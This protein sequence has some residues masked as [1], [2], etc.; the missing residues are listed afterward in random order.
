MAHRQVMDKHGARKENRRAGAFQ[1]DGHAVCLTAEAQ[2]E[3]KACK[4][5]L[6]L[7]GKRR[8]WRMR[9]YEGSTVNLLEYICDMV[10]QPLLRLEMQV[11]K[12]SSS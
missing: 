5:C 8:G 10:R 7:E 3:N 1:H 6:H 2:S 11:F 4:L 9:K 12:V